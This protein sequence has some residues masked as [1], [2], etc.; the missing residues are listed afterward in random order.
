MNNV[1]IVGGGFAGM[2][3]ALTL[4][5]LGIGVTLF[6]R[7]ETLGGHV[8]NWHT[9][10]PDMSLAEDTLQ[11][12][13]DAVTSKNIDIRFNTE[14][15]DISKNSVTLKGGEVV[16][17]AAVVICSGYKLFDAK[18]KQEYGYGI[19]DKVITSADFEKENKVEEICGGTPKT[20]AFVHCVGSRDQQVQQ[21]HCSRV[22]CVTG[23]KQAIKVRK[24]YPDCEVYNFYMDIRMFGAGY[25]EMYRTAQQQYH[26]HFI[27]GRVS[28]VTPKLSGEVLIKTEDTL[29]ARPMRISVDLL[30]LMIGMCAGD[31]TKTFAASTGIT[32]RP[33]GFIKPLNSFEGNGLTG[34]DGIFM[35][36]CAAAPH[37]I[38]ETINS[39]SNVALEVAKYL[40]K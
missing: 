40:K 14:V 4:N 20:I 1:I 10:F 17:A 5:Q 7:E 23:V 9:L 37:N 33:S 31:D 34:V 21:E 27:R 16:A 36:G 15:V 39:G 38:Q 19:Y 35:A 12:M 26:I 11:H 8:R 6:E 18:L 24:L 2:Q 32:L 29:L 28:E 22:C 25:E 30:V 13:I 3:T